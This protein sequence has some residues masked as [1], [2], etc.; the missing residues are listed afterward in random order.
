MLGRDW[1]AAALAGQV[2]DERY[3]Q[4]WQVDCYKAAAE[5]SKASRDAKPD[6][7]RLP[8]RRCKGGFSVHFLKSAISG[9]GGR[10]LVSAVSRAGLRR[11]LSETWSPSVVT[12]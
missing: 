3:G 2:S 6:I 12:Y 7:L 10:S 1:I 5:D 4:G 9:S 11:Q 8:R